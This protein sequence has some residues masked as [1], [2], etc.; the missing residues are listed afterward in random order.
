MISLIN[1]SL[2]SLECYFNRN[3]DFN[4]ITFSFSDG[5]E[6]R[7]SR[8]ALSTRSDYFNKMFNGGWEESN[9]S[10]IPIEDVTYQCFKHLIYFL[11][12]G[13]LDDHLPLFVLKD[14]CI[15]ADIRNIPEL[16]EM[17]VSKITD[18]ANDNNWNYVVHWL[19]DKKYF[20][21]KLCTKIHS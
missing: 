12:T 4:D 21:E 18:Q 14:L 15:E 7:A 11:Y 10:I 16:S 6:I 8:S 2:P 17:V 20:I 19:E 13:K 1:F 5:S 3:D 9:A